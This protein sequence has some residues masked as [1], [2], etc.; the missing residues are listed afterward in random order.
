MKHWPLLVFCIAINRAFA[1]EIREC[2]TQHLHPSWIWCDDFEI[3]RLDRYFEYKDNEGRFVR[4][5][6]AGLGGSTGMR[7]RFIA[8]D[9]HAGALRVAFG[10][11]PAPYFRPVDSGE[12]RYRE[13]YWRA[14]LRLPSDW[15][16]GGAD[17]FSRALVIASKDWATAMMAHL[18]SGG[19]PG[20]RD[21]L[22]L[23]PASGTT[24]EGIL[25]TR[26]YNDFE[27]L[28]WL[29]YQR[30]QLPLFD[31]QHVGSWY[32]IEAHVRLNDKHRNNGVFEF[33]IDDRRQA[34]L[35]NLNWL[36]S[37]DEFGINAIFFENYWSQG[38]IGVQ[39]RYWDNI[40]VSQ[41]RVG[42]GR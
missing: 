1:I 32:C 41:A 17:K 22:G 27:R 12:R 14:L 10:K 9:P 5:S 16:G 28:R 21:V 33:W 37:Y 36:G 11:T 20:S 6:D 25:R 7:A 35:D 40:I 29:G 38:P 31:R 26:H 19:A 34:R 39:D 23:D 3:D 15:R 18:W 30:G 2:D 24:P 8:G 4:Q 42:C 13:V